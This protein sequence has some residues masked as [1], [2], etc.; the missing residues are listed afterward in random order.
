MY[1]S[2]TGR[3]DAGGA[4]PYWADSQQGNPIFVLRIGLRTDDLILPSGYLHHYPLVL[5]LFIPRLLLKGD[6]EPDLC[7]PSSRRVPLSIASSR[8][9]CFLKKSCDSSCVGANKLLTLV[10]QDGLK[11]NWFKSFK[12]IKVLMAYHRLQQVFKDLTGLHEASVNN[13]NRQLC[14]NQYMEGFIQM[15]ISWLPSHHFLLQ[16]N[17]ISDLSSIIQNKSL[18]VDT[19]KGSLGI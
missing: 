2:G 7:I 8:S 15:L 19:H 10:L 1:L 13:F 4:R 14:L 5:A 16:N 6:A 12:R 11:V 18:D 9:C 17:S 3:P